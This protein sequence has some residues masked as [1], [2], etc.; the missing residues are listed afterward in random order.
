MAENQYQRTVGE[1]TSLAGV[2]FGPLALTGE[3]APHGDV[4]PLDFEELRFR[5]YDQSPEVLAA[6]A[7]MNAD[8]ITLRREIVEPIPNIVVTGGSGYNFE[9]S[10]TV[11]ALSVAIEVPLWNRNQGTIR[12]AEADLARQQREVRRT[13]LVLRRELFRVYQ[14]YLTGLQHVTEYRDV[15]LPE[16]KAVYQA[17]L[18]SYQENRQEWPDVLDAQREY[19]D[20]RQMYVEHLTTWRENEVLL[21][22]FLLHGGLDAPTGVTPPGHIDAVPQ[23]R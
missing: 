12:Q 20:L 17:Q 21:A 16:A 5:L 3:L 14:D 7:K 1:L 23:P 2:E 18:D 22:G 9:A 4:N 8:R 10:Q 11:G 15:I 6:K 13:E 19:F